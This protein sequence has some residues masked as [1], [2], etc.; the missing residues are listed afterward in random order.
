[1]GEFAHCLQGHTACELKNGHLGGLKMVEWVWKRA[2]PSGLARCKKLLL[3]K[4]FFILISNIDKE[5][6]SIKLWLLTQADKYVVYKVHPVKKYV[7]I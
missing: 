5:K 4:F 1:M 3:N 2:Y 7:P 6:S